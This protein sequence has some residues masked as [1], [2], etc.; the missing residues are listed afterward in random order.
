MKDLRKRQE[1]VLKS[2]GKFRKGLDKSNKAFRKKSKN[3][4]AKSMTYSRKS[5]EG[6]E[7][8]MTE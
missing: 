1:L 8:V 6:H 3:N 5:Q 7:R 2:K 4:L